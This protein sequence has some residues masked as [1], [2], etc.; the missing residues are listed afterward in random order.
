MYAEEL[1][2][3]GQQKNECQLIESNNLLEARR[4]KLNDWQQSLSVDGSCPEIEE[5]AIRSFDGTLLSEYEEPEEEM[6][7]Q[8]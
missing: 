2:I 6:K 3:A 5:T 7:L 4:V 8:Q 1:A